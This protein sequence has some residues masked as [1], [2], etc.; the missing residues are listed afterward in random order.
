MDVTDVQTDENVPVS[1]ITQQTTY[2]HVANRLREL[3]RKR[4]R[5]RER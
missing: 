4:M 2:A 3:E 1:P 5:K